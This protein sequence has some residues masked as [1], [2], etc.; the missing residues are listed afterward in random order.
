MACTGD[1][2][3]KFAMLQ[4]R[5][6][7]QVDM[8]DNRASPDVPLPSQAFGALWRWQACP[9]SFHKS[10]CNSIHADPACCDLPGCS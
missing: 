1:T 3:G 9:T 4:W 5:H 7:H 2:G 10:V 8:K 6:M